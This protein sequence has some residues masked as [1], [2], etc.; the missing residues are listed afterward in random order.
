MHKIANR[1]DPQPGWVIDCQETALIL[2]SNYGVYLVHYSKPE[3]LVAA[4]TDSCYNVLI[5][6]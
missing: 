5:K 3:P 4:G 6:L 2:F 1:G